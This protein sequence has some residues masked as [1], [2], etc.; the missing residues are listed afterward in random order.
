MVLLLGE[1][2]DLSPISTG[3]WVPLVVFD[4][5]PPALVNRHWSKTTGGTLDLT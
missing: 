3:F 2:R 5:C 1:E 4:Q